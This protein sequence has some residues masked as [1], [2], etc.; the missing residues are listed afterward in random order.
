[1]KMINIAEKVLICQI[2]E[3]LSFIVKKIIS[4]LSLFGF[5]L[6]ILSWLKFCVSTSMDKCRNNV[7]CLKC[8]IELHPIKSYDP[9]FLQKTVSFSV[10]SS[11]VNIKIEFVL[12]QLEKLLNFRCAFEPWKLIHFLQLVSSHCDKIWRLSTFYCQSKKTSNVSSIT[13]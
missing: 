2:L 4:N 6:Y 3:D 11:K 5:M 8:T 12:I 1:M 10:Y 7:K 9:R 13:T